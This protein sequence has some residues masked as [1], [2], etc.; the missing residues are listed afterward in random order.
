MENDVQ[1]GQEKRF[2]QSV[3]YTVTHKLPQKY[4]INFEQ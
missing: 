3:G 2:Y 1:Y 4:I